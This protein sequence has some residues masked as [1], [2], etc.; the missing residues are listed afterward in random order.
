M[1]VTAVAKVGGWDIEG[2]VTGRDVCDVT[3]VVEVGR[4][5]S[6]GDGRCVR[7]VCDLAAVVEVE[8]V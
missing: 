6:A 3:A 7:N 8:D 1:T 4:V 2:K 5:S